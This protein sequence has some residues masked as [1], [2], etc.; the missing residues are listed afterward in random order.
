MSPV[1]LLVILSQSLP[2]VSIMAVFVDLDDDDVDLP[3][4]TLNAMKPIWSST[5]PSEP[6]AEPATTRGE[7][8]GIHPKVSSDASTIDNNDAD[9]DEAAHE[10]AVQEPSNSMAVALGCYP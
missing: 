3:Q 5:A 1:L 2:T 8:E 9:R 6:S 7:N 4:Q 10:P